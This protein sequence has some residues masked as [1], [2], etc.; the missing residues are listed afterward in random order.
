[1]I[2]RQLLVFDFFHLKNMYM[3]I[4]L[5]SK[6]KKENLASQKLHFYL[7]STFT[8]LK[9]IF[10]FLFSFRLCSY[11]LYHFNNK[12]ALFFIIYFLTT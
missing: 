8:F 7:K 9:N 10:N 4:I 12:V 5:L 3:F 6:N 2:E 1:M 11:F